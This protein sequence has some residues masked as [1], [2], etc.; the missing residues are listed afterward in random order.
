MNNVIYLS[1]IIPVFNCLE[2][3]K[4]CL[5]SL[6]NSLKS[7]INYEVI[8]VDDGSTDG[9]REFLKTLH[10]D[11]YR[12]LLNVDK[13]NFAI[14]NNRAAAI[15][16]GNIFCLLNNDTELAP[17]WIEPML[18]AIERIPDAGFIGNVQKI[19]AT[20]RYD[21][22]GICFPYWQTPIHFGQHLRKAPPALAKYSR[23]GAVTAACILIR[24]E[25]FQSAGGFDENY[26]N[27]CEDIDL[28]LRLHRAGYW[29]YVA[30]ESEILH[31]KGASP[32]RKRHNN[33]NLDRLKGTWASYIDENFVTRDGR[34]AARSYLRS[35][36]AL[37]ARINWPKL[38][39]SLSTLLKPQPYNA[40]KGPEWIDPSIAADRK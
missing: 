6:K 12:I 24:K 22:F 23:W 18:E 35:A 31:H 10:P 29:H 16:R 15:A 32:G 38:L 25:V 8:I 2:L 20:G 17:G 7:E 4:L 19:P 21:H 36:I 9:T 26:V 27:G 39:R 33:K 5:D 13:G 1:V 11:T 28:C 30:H 3:T 37:P 14:N 40:L 34:L